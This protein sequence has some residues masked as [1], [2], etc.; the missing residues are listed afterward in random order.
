AYR[1]E[2]ALT[3]NNLGALLASR[4]ER[5]K[6]EEQYR[7][8][9]ALLEGLPAQA[10]AVTESQLTLGHCYLSLGTVLRDGEQPADSLGWPAKPV[11]VL[12]LLAEKE[13][14]LAT[15]RQLLR[16]AH[17]ARAEALERLD[18]DAE[19]VPD[20][21]RVLAL[22]APAE[23]EHPLLRRANARIWAGQVA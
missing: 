14:R 17:Q 21:D 8:A 11:R 7:K 2:L 20:W 9:L 4:G 13:P 18:R 10:R 12:A 6:A 5:A 3:R 16:T 23:R 19:A 22:S 15:A 1:Q